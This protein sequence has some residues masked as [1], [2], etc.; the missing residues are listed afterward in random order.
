M[1]HETVEVSV[2]FTMCV[3][4]FLFMVVE[5]RRLFGQDSL[6]LKAQRYLAEARWRRPRQAD[7][8][9]QEKLFNDARVILERRRLERIRAA[10]PGLNRCACLG[11]AFMLFIGPAES[12]VTATSLTFGA[13]VIFVGRCAAKRLTMFEAKLL[14]S[15]LMLVHIGSIVPY[16]VNGVSDIGMSGL[17]GRFV[18]RLC[19]ALWMQELQVGVFWNIVFSLTFCV[20]YWVTWQGEDGGVS[21]AGAQE[22]MGREVCMCIVLLLL[23]RDRVCSVRAEA[24]NLARV[25][26]LS[27]EG[28]AKT[29]LLK[30]MCDV[31][32]LLDSDLKI[33]Q[34]CPQ[35][36]HMLQAQQ[37]L[38]GDTLQNYM[39]TEDDQHRFQQFMVGGESHAESEPEDLA[40]IL[41]LHMRD[42]QGVDRRVELLRAKLVNVDGTVGHLVGIRVQPDEGPGAAADSGIAEIGGQGGA[43]AAAG[44][45]D[46]SIT[47]SFDALRWTILDHSLPFAVLCGELMIGTSI[48]NLVPD[49]F[50]FYSWVQQC[51]MDAFAGQHVPSCPV[52]HLLLRWKR[53]AHPCR[54]EIRNIELYQLPANSFMDPA[55]GGQSGTL[56]MTIRFARMKS[57]PLLSLRA[58]R[59]R[60]FI[61]SAMVE[62]LSGYTPIDD[63]EIEG[64]DEDGD[65][66][67]FSPCAS[68]S[69]AYLPYTALGT[70]IARLS[71]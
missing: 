5:C 33:A 54:A 17:L 59:R 24:L 36:K 40:E 34:P 1:D 30:A 41:N 23:V 49:S 7:T 14:Y 65:G 67:Q 57:K 29:S 26:S 52:D 20:I 48:K 12:P 16:A 25:Q 21:R 28:S 61:L 8:P 2:R 44:E 37:A 19:C 46:D 11:T 58:A 55:G 4:F 68:H 39:A 45:L 3:Y 56:I 60:G 9:L 70:G 10:L 64:I 15:M 6:L 13:I 69:A 27:T 50:A 35:L 38:K 47:L 51:A 62:M 31:V 53:A 66:D 43:P 63:D 22:V 32:V 71:I 18:S 42:W